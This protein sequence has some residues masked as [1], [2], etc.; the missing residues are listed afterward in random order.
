MEKELHMSKLVVNNN[1]TL[2]GVMQAPGRADEDLRG[3]FEHGGWAQPYFDSVMG[4][5]A[6]EGIAKGGDLLLG[7]GPTRTSPPS[8]PIRPRTTPSRR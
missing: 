2:D 1:V 4:R 5:V 3:G 8:G 7:H 6:A